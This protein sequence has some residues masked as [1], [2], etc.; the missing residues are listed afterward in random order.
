MRRRTNWLEA[1]VNQFRE[2]F[3]FRNRTPQPQPLSSQ[4]KKQENSLLSVG[5]EK[6]VYLEFLLKILA[7]TAE[8][9]GDKQVVY[10]LVEANI[11]YLNETFVEVLRDWGTTTLANMQPDEAES[12]A[13]K[14]FN[15]SLFMR[16]CSLG[17]KARNVEIAIAGYEIALIVYTRTALPQDW[18]MTQNNLGLAY[19][20]RIFGDKAENIELA[21]SAYNAA[22]SVRT[23]TA[24]PQN[25]ADTLFNLGLLYQDT[26]KFTEAFT[27]FRSAIETVELLRGEIISGDE[28]KRKQAEEWNSLY[29]CM[30]EV[31]LELE[32]YTEAIEYIEQSKTRNLVETL[33]SRDSYPKI[34][35]SEE[36]KNQLQQLQQK[37]EEEN[38]RIEQA[39]KSNPQNIDS[40]QLYKL[41]QQREQLITRIIGFHPIRYDEIKNLLDSET[42]IIQWYIFKNAFRA[43]IITNAREKPIIWQSEP[44]DLENLKAWWSNDY[45][46]LYS[47]NKK[48][49]RYI[50]D[51]KLTQ[52][53]QI[54]H[55]QEILSLIPNQ[56]E[57]AIL[58]S[59]RY[60][61]LLPLHALPL[62]QDTQNQGYLIDKFP[63]GVSYAPSCQLLRFTQN[64]ATTFTDFCNQVDTE[65]F[66][67]TELSHLFAIQNPT[68][69]LE[70]SDIEV[71]SIATVFEP[72]HILQKTEATIAAF[73]KRLSDR[74]FRTTWLHFSCHGYFNFNLPEKSALQLAGSLIS[75]PPSEA[76]TSR[77]LRLSEQEAIDFQKCLTLEDTFQ[78]SLPNC[79]LVTLS[80]CETGLVDF[81]NTSDEY[82]GL[83]SGFIRAGAVNIISSLWAIDDFSTSLLMIK[84]YENLQTLT[85]NVPLALNKA[86]QWFRHV[87]QQELLQWLDGKT[88][89]DV[90]HKQKIKQRLSE[91]YKPEHQPF[92]HPGFWAAFVQSENNTRDD[93]RYYLF[94][95]QGTWGQGDMGDMGTW[96]TWGHGGHGRHGGHGERKIYERELV[97][98]IQSIGAISWKQITSLK[99]LHKW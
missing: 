22:L 76:D 29:R 75:S 86:Q 87:T 67:P 31:C 39:E 17:D 7:A 84:F 60:L 72:H 97:L 15:F 1:L 78:L 82:V 43:F 99:L 74:S 13:A 28:T 54:L 93:L 49:W 53:A 69:N 30:V 41:R 42:V 9:N 92:K 66:Q 5:T 79:R 51:E 81:T 35:V 77:Y 33:F 20:N 96:E 46:H 8:S 63:K 32:K 98:K 47:N 38:R 94:M 24:F 44:E 12:T 16:Q 23:R 40:T 58:I 95:R 62:L 25:N 68:D 61:H 71:E 14:V 85:R 37:I 2:A 52:L 89:I 10:P 34:S 80:A 88:N 64:Q 70:F 55:I 21:I 6:S 19:R 56:Y 50:L 4:A 45:L 48:Y 90:Q 18:A 3:N 91:N 11:K 83:P 65:G 57:K 26:Q 73:T 36:L 27:T 59:H